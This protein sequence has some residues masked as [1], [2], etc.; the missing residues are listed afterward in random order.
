MSDDGKQSAMVWSKFIVATIMAL[1]TLGIHA[2]VKDL[3]VLVM[4]APYA[5]MGLKIDLSGLLG[6]G[7]K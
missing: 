3:P 7:K 5:I 6:L 2:F 1:A 4:A